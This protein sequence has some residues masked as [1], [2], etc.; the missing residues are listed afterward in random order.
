MTPAEKADLF[1]D[2]ANNVDGWQEAV[3]AVWNTCLLPDDKDRIFVISQGHGGGGGGGGGDPGEDVVI[4]G[5]VAA[6]AGDNALIIATPFAGGAPIAESIPFITINGSEKLIGNASTST[7]LYAGP[8][9]GV[10]SAYGAIGTSDSIFWNT[11][12][13]G[14]PLVGDEV[15]IIRYR[16]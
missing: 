7:P 1:L 11:T 14:F 4:T 2:V 9:S 8:M 15:Y 3:N 10:S 13:A 6:A 16:K 5:T 12:F